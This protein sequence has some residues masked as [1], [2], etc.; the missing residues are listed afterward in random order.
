[1]TCRHR[2]SR[3]DHVRDHLRGEDVQRRRCSRCSEIVGLGPANDEPWHVQAE[4]AAARIIASA[5]CPPNSCAGTELEIIA[6]WNEIDDANFCD[7]W[8]ANW[9]ALV[10][11]T[12]EP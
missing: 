12:E 8:P 2:Y 11:A 1:M 4:I 7:R 9:L 10:I 6:H 3:A 5:W